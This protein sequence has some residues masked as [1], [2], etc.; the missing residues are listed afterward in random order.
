MMILNLL[1]FSQK[2]FAIHLAYFETKQPLPLSQGKSAK[3]CAEYAKLYYKG[4]NF[5]IYVLDF[6]KYQQVI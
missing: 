1:W 4:S 3:Y 6:T 5:Q 2:Y